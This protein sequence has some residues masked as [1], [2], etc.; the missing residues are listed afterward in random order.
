MKRLI[1][2]VYLWLAFSAVTLLACAIGLVFNVGLLLTTGGT[3]I[4][5]F[6]TVLCLISHLCGPAEGSLAEVVINELGEHT[7]IVPGDEFKKH[8]AWG[9]VLIILGA[10]L[11]LIGFFVKS[12]AG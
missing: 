8:N 10:S 9:L 1:L 2:S 11:G 5:V 12:V 3:L 6:G 4:G 7:Y